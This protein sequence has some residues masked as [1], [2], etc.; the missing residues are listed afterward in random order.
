[1]REETANEFAGTSDDFKLERTLLHRVAVCEQG[2]LVRREPLEQRARGHHLDWELAI[3][4]NLAL[5][6]GRP[7]R[8]RQHLLMH[9]LAFCGRYVDGICI[10]Y[11][12]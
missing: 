9:P 5:Q 4:S 3:L 10:I 2:G 6:H 1:M 8:V 11:K 12:K 7:K